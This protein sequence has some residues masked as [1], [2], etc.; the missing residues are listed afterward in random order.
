METSFSTFF[1]FR[2]F[3][4]VYRQVVSSDNTAGHSERTFARH[5]SYFYGSQ[6]RAF[7]RRPR[8]QATRS[9]PAI[10][11]AAEAALGVSLNAQSQA[12]DIPG[13]SS[14]A[15]FLQ[16]SVSLQAHVKAP[17]IYSLRAYTE[18]LASSLNA[19]AQAPDNPSQTLVSD[20]HFLSL[21][22]YLEELSAS[23][24]AQD[25]SPDDFHVQDR[26]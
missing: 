8:P 13:A 3:L 16:H 20:L 1:L 18:E 14:R 22:A 23:F 2:D 4:Q 24:N 11:A 7:L 9:P 12:P 17:D 19:Q 6:A 15:V 21:R 25:Q 10:P 5:Q 26:Q